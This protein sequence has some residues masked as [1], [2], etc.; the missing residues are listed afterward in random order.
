MSLCVQWNLCSCFEGTEFPRHFK[1]KQIKGKVFN[2][3]SLLASQNFLPFCC[4]SFCLSLQCALFGARVVSVPVSCL[5]CLTSLSKGTVSVHRS[6]RFHSALFQQF[7]GDCTKVASSSFQLLLWIGGR[8][9]T[10]TSRRAKQEN[11]HQQ[12]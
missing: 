9:A 4:M 3:L 5:S 12:F 2:A 1:L 10:A 6:H 11:Q 8:L 7:A